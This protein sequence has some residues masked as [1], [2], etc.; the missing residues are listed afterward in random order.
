MCGSG[1]PEANPSWKTWFLTLFLISFFFFS[2]FFLAF[3]LYQKKTSSTTTTN[4]KQLSHKKKQLQ[5]KQEVFPSKCLAF[6]WHMK[7]KNI[8]FSIVFVK[9]ALNIQ[10][11]VIFKETKR[12]SSTNVCTV[13][14]KNGLRQCSL[15]FLL[16]LSGFHTHPRTHAHTHTHMHAFLELAYIDI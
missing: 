10:T 4:D 9:H 3:T 16:Y 5:Q 15:S 7:F 8:F 11:S 1:K 12:S 13:K 2:F 6:F 14:L